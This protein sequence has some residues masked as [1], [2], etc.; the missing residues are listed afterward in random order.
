MAHDSLF[1]VRGHSLATKFIRKTRLPAS[2]PLRY[3]IRSI[4]Q[5]FPV[6]GRRRGEA[7]GGD[8]EGGGEGGERGWVQGDR[9]TDGET[10]E[11]R[12]KGKKGI[13]NRDEGRCGLEKKKKKK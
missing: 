11:T 2:L 6:S 7:K 3:V 1:D 5:A 13:C 12:W 4:V 10:R 8:R 9:K